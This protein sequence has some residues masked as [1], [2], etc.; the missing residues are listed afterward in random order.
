MLSYHFL[1]G[2]LLYLVFSGFPPQAK[3][4]NHMYIYIYIYVLPK[5][6]EPPGTFIIVVGGWV[7]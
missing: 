5:D 6:K 7:L 2:D 3:A 4:I 1:I